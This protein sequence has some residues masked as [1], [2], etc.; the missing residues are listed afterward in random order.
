MTTTT[1]PTQ[2]TPAWLVAHPNA[3]P[4][5]SPCESNRVQRVWID[6]H[7]AQCSSHFPSGRRGQG[8]E[9]MFRS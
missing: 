1:Q 5:L 6:F 9:L 8:A 7:L 3:V 4:D 2:F